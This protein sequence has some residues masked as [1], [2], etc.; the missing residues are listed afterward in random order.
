MTKT[1]YTAS[2]AFSSAVPRQTGLEFSPGNA[3]LSTTVP[4]DEMTSLPSTAATNDKESRLL[5][6]LGELESTQG[7][8]DQVIEA[9]NRLVRHYLSSEQLSHAERALESVYRFAVK[10]YGEK[11]VVIAPILIELAFVNYKLSAYERAKS[12]LEPA[13][14]IQEREYGEVSEQ[15]AFV[16]HKLGRVN[17]A[18]GHP[19]EAE[20]LYL[21]SVTIYQNTYSE[22]DS[23]IIIARTDLA[24]A[25]RKRR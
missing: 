16:I 4:I 17:E 21:R 23:Q 15:A 9:Y 7:S 6:R 19:A 5:G 11:N 3:P 10:T 24:R 8:N 13:L 22:D 1:R 25:R 2:G 14:Q 20:K 18:L 12:Y